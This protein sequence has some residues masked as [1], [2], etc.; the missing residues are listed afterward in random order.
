[1]SLLENNKQKMT[2]TDI[3]FE[4]SAMILVIATGASDKEAP[5]GEIAYAYKKVDGFT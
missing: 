3:T 5:T 1:M 4:T 2:Y